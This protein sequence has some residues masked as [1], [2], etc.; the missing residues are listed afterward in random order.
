MSS[1]NFMILTPTGPLFEG[2]VESLVVEATDGK[3]GVLAHHAP[4][5]A[6]LASGDICIKQSGEEK[7]FA[8]DAGLLEVGS[9]GSV[10][11]LATAVS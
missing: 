5:V 7:T 10:M 11:I 4:M 6:S 8:A 3:L 9:D 1:F 2:E